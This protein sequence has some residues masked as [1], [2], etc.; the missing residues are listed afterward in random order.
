MLC[1][2]MISHIPRERRR[3]KRPRMV[4]GRIALTTSWISCRLMPR[5]LQQPS[6]S[7]HRQR[8]GMPC[9]TFPKPVDSYLYRGYI[10][11]RQRPEEPEIG[12]RLL[13]FPPFVLYT[14]LPTYLLTYL[15]GVG[16]KRLI[17]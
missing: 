16:E 8:L 12:G 1:S 3:I 17:V 13:E 5:E 10:K 15:R 11:C 14:S 2:T 6:R 4:Q 7:W 9:R